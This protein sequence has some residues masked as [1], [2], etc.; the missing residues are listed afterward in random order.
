M[1]LS[2]SLAGVIP[3]QDYASTPAPDLAPMIKALNTCAP[4]S[5]S[6]LGPAACAAS[7]GAVEDR[8]R[9]CAIAGHPLWHLPTLQSTAEQS[10]HADALL[11]AYIEHG[12]GFIQY[13]GGAF[14]FVLLDISDQ[15]LLA[16]VDRLGQKAL[17]YQ[18]DD[19]TFTF[20]TDAAALGKDARSAMSAQG[21]YNYVYFHMVPAPNTLF[22]GITKLPAAHMLHVRNGRVTTKRYWQ[23][24]FR[25]QLDCSEEAAATELR[26]VLKRSVERATGNEPAVA[27][28]LS[29]GLDSST[30][31]G[32]LAENSQGT[33][34]AYS[35]GFSAEGYDE[36]A[37]ARI[38]AKHFGLH[39]HEYYVTP[40]DVVSALP[41]I[42]TSY[43][44]PFGNSSA[45]P[46]W[47]C[48]RF[49]AENGV[50][51]LLAG[52]GGDELFA[53]NERY[54]KQQVFER[55]LA[56]PHML[57][58][59]ALEPLIQLMP[60]TLPL[61]SKA[62]SFVAQANI[63]LPDRLQ[64]YNF[65]HQHAAQEIFSDE[66]LRHVDTAEPVALQRAVYQAVA[67][68]STLNRMLFQDWQFTLADNDLRK[69]SRMC[70]KANVDVTYPMLDDALV[71][72]STTIPGQLK[73]RGNDLR[74]FYKK[75]LTGWLPDA[76]IH[77]E[78]HGFGLP[79]GVWMRE[80]KP[81]QE[82]AYD[83]LL[84][85]KNRPYFK[86]DFIDHAIALHRDGH[87]SY[88]GELVWILMVLELWLGTHEVL[89]TA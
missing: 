87:A 18:Q 78:K 57:R 21:L 38:T 39:L 58:Q 13:L 8:T 9:L 20:A 24:A 22:E 12:E 17:Y 76:T 84:K 7:Q 6:A 29:G 46:A 65:L 71:E 47:F 1:Y 27:A 10:G 35:I 81:L 40:D 60:D 44:E 75:A 4:L 5:V 26:N 31:A 45:L 50:K 77:K 34:H 52:D 79:F 69:V 68:A 64:H 25:E 67:P 49:A 73:L 43:S 15:L 55:Y 37:Y 88:Y 82:M 62:K 66:F 59:H 56:L 51:R 70:E 11:Q 41:D 30:V 32:M 54:A 28:F 63:P 89:T 83:N 14:C 86:A 53:G 36:M 16:G 48:A 42:A 19:H 2:R 72:F 23:P 74:Y 33:A 80:H 85:L 61:S 3:V